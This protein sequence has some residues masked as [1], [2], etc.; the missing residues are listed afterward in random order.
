MMGLPVPGDLLD[1]SL[2]HRVEMIRA[3]RIRLP[4]PTSRLHMPFA[5]FH[6]VVIFG[7]IAA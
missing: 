2:D 5:L 4:L 1:A 6:F 7:Q 3:R